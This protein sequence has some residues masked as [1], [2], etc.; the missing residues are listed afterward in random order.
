MSTNV[1]P[2]P[3]TILQSPNGRAAILAMFGNPANP[4]G[5]HVNPAWENA[6]IQLV[7]PPGWKFL[8]QGDNG[9]V[10]ISGIRIHRLIA[11]N[12]LAVMAGIRQH[13]AAETDGSDAA[14]QNFIHQNRLDITGGGFNFRPIT[15]GSVLSL[16]AFGIAIDWDPLHNPRQKPL[17]KQLPDWWYKIWSDNGFSN[18]CHFLTPDPMHVQFATGA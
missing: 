6:N 12:F 10:S 13:A 7:S 3:A 11:P 9:L 4:D 18:G 17:T 14:I 5:I 16:H 1:I 2:Q 8:F 15:A